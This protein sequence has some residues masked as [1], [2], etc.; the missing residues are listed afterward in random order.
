MTILYPSLLIVLFIFLT[1]IRIVR[2]TH[3]ALAWLGSPG[4]AGS[5]TNRSWLSCATGSV[6]S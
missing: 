1:G 3:R 5:A 4:R 6:A 2:P